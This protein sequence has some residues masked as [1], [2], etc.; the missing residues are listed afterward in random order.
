M[1]Q[2]GQSAHNVPEHLVQ[3][4][5]FDPDVGNGLVH[6]NNPRGHVR[7]PQCQKPKRAPHPVRSL[8]KELESLRERG[9][10]ETMANDGTGQV[11]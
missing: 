4:L 5:K 10:R 7:R 9:M 6:R 8:E 2:W 11:D 3:R 1:S